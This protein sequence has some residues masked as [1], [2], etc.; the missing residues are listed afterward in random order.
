MDTLEH[1][2]EVIYKMFNL[3]ELSEN[4]VLNL[5]DIINQTCQQVEAHYNTR[6]SEI[7]N[8][9]F[10]VIFARYIKW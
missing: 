8:Y 1:T 5:P 9:D 3:R 7:R 2:H 4:A 10:G 6:K